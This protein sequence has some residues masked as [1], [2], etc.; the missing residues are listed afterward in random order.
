MA[1]A[2][3]CVYHPDRAAVA[4]CYQC[5]KPICEE[6][7]VIEAA[8]AFCSKK[9]A[10]RYRTVELHYA[11]EETKPSRWRMVYTI[12]CIVLALVILRF[13]I[14]AGAGLEI[15]FLKKLDELLPKLLF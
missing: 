9:C 12:I 2:A 8:R 14:T 10:S 6:C 4:N 15:G 11:K 3:T 5:H 13:A 7:R 1:R